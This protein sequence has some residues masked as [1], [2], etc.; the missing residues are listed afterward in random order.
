ME[1]LALALSILALVFTVA[2]LGWTAYKQVQINR[3][4]K[5]FKR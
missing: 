4:K 3:L 1:S 5:K 2:L